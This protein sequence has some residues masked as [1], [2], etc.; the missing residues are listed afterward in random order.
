MENELNINTQREQE[1]LEQFKIRIRVM[2]E[3]GSVS[4]ISILLGASSFSD[5][6]DRINC[7][8]EIME[9][10][11]GLILDVQDATEKV[12]AAKEDM[13]AEMA[14]QEEVFAAYQEKLVDLAD[15]Q[16][17]AAELLASLSADSAEYDA[18]LA[19]VKSLQSSISVKISDM[20]EALA[21]QERI[22]AEQI[23]AAQAAAKAA[24]GGEKWYGDSAG[25][26]S[27]QEI[28]DYALGF[29][30]VKYVYGGT[31]PS[32]FD[33]SGL[34]YYC[35][36]H[37][38]YSVNRTATAQSYNGKV[39]SSTELQPG[40]LV[41]FSSSAYGKT[42]GHVGIY[43]GNG[44]FIHAPHTGD[45]VKISSLSQSYYKT[46]YWAPDAS[47][48]SDNNINHKRSSLR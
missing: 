32:G 8:K 33:C 26:A 27:G 25:T 44:Q 11:N 14:E 28:V 17:E 45:V 15:Q 2:E 19:S 37:F 29:L 6:L 10:D 13:E 18:Q 48:H 40:D 38:G 5:L 42:I 4:Y 31:S 35:Y 34:V 47:S 36:R 3:N 23:A 16:T 21:E 20:E 46:H 24:A 9:Y 1:L 12:Q 7:M 41:F 30:G 43:I 39:V 22:K